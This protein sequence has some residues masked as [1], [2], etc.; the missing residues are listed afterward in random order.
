MLAYQGQ[1]DEALTDASIAERLAAD[2]GQFFLAG[3]AAHNHAFTAGLQGD[4]ATAL[5]S[6]A[7]A[8]ALYAQVGYPGRSAG[9]FASDRCELMIAAGLH[10][11]ARENAELAVRTLEGVGDV[12]DLA[13]ARLL[14]ARACLAQND[15]DAAYREAP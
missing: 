14:L 13:E 4:I 9:V 12:M 1:I 5:A 7:R 8:D 10:A 15:A 6:F 11:E 3:G 2:N